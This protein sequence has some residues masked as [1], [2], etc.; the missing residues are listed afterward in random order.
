MKTET[1]NLRFGP[2]TQFNV[3]QHLKKNQEL[4]FLAMTGDWIKLNTSIGFKHYK[5]IEVKAD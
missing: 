2:S 4:V 1:L 5:Y 3:E